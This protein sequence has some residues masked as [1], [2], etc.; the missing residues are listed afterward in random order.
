[1]V[2]CV[3]DTAD[4]FAYSSFP[5]SSLVAVSGGCGGSLIMFLAVFT[6]VSFI[7]HQQPLESHHPSAKVEVIIALNH[8]TVY[9]FGRLSQAE[10][11]QLLLAPRGQE[12]G[13]Q[14]RSLRFSPPAIFTSSF[15]SCF[16]PLFF[17][18]PILSSFPFVGVL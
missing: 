6:N 14:S 11:G 2:V 13:C 4:T 8:L 12:R 18:A 3:G 15:V 17:L 9:L 7:K 16:A 5:F 10:G 1:M